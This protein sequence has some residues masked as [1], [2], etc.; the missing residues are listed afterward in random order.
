MK[1]Y[2]FYIVLSGVL[3]SSCKKDSLVKSS[4]TTLPP[5]KEIVLENPFDVFLKEDTTYSVEV[6]ADERVLEN[7]NIRVE[8]S[9][10]KIGN[11]S[12]FKWLRPKDNTIELYINSRPLKEIRVAETCNIHTL[13]PITSDEFG[14]VISTKANQ[15][16]LELNCNTFYTWNN[17]S[18]GGNLTLRG[19]T[20][21][22]KIW[23]FAIMSVDA[24]DL[25]AQ[26]AIVENSSQGDCSIWAEDFLEYSI[27]G[28]GDIHI[29]GS[30]EIIERQVT[31]SGRL[32]RH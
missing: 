13:N 22:L 19:N 11:T 14:L 30:P 2:L 4:F 20:E 12:S 23:N 8:D 21:I 3:F 7:M 27:K 17:F 26:H 15:A 31:S 28:I 32:I 6:I 1:N 5:F 10:L 18:S 29:Y 9:I 24:Q 25:I 16:N